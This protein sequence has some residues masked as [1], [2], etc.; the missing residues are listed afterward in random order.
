M[1]T[2]WACIATTSSRPVHSEGGTSHFSCSSPI[3]SI[4]RSAMF[5]PPVCGNAHDNHRGFAMMTTSRW[6]GGGTP[7]GGGVPATPACVLTTHRR[8]RLHVPA[9]QSTNSSDDF[10]SSQPKFARRGVLLQEIFEHKHHNPGT[11]THFPR[12]WVPANSPPPNDPPSSE[13]VLTVALN[14]AWIHQCGEDPSYPTPTI[15][16]T[17]PLG[18]DNILGSRSSRMNRESPG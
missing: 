1:Q 15:T 3:S 12:I 4:R 16:S 2:S 11:P 7:P 14:R 6:P 13:V 5:A 10:T 17:L 18:K 9:T 8:C